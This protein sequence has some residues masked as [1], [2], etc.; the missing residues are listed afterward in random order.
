MKISINLTDEHIKLLRVLQN[1]ITHEVL[2]PFEL[3]RGA[4]IKA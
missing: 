4:F 2:S 3:I 1:P